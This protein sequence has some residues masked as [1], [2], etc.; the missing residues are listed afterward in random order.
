MK[1]K[2]IFNDD[3]IVETLERVILRKDGHVFTNGIK[4]KWIAEFDKQTG[5]FISISVE[6]SDLEE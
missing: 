5:E 2:F 1:R 3:E 6:I 4:E